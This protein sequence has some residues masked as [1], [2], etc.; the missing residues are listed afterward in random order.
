MQILSES[1]A[2][3]EIA[4]K[5]INM[6]S[7]TY[8]IHPTHLLAAMR[9]RASTNNVTM[10]ILYPRHRLLLTYVGSRFKTPTLREFISL[11][12]SLFSHS[13]KTHLLWKSRRERSTYVMIQCH[14]M[15]EQIGGCQTNHVVF[16]RHPAFPGREQRYW[17]FSLTKAS[18][19]FRP[20]KV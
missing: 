8:S 4:I 12:I 7:V 19:T 3:E 13:P 17:C 20:L 5:L 9:N 2:G 16:W 11:W 1:L 18:L 15:V 10:D 6:L 14:Q